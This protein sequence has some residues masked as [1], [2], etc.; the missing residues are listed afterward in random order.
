MKSFRPVHVWIA[1][2][3]VVLDQ[4]VKAVVRPR[5][6]LFDSIAVIPGFFSLTRV[7][8]TGAAFGLLNA[9]DIPYKTAVMALVQTAALVGLAAYAATL[10]P[11]QRLTRIGLSFVIGGAIGNLIDRVTAGYVLDFFDFYWRGWHFWAFNIADASIT[12]GVA[13]MILDLIGAGQSRVSRTV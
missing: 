1:I 12:I 5:L 2:G 6:G 7:H 3:V 4:L 11:G 10:A 8:N 9:I 13:L